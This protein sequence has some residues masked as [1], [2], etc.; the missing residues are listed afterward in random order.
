MDEESEFNSD[1]RKD[2]AY[3]AIM[4]WLAGEADF[5]ESVDLAGHMDDP[6]FMRELADRVTK[7]NERL[8]AF[9]RLAKLYGNG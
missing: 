9:N 7:M 3:G 5:L 8:T 4:R 2:K 6:E 1:S